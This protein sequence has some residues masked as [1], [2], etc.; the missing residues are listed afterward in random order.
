MRT[1]SDDGSVAAFE[2]DRVLAVRG[3]ETGAGIDDI[4]DRKMIRIGKSMVLL[5]ITDKISDINAAMRDVSD[6]NEIAN[7]KRKRDKLQK[8]L[9]LLAGIE[10]DDLK[11]VKPT[12]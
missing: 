1:A 4:G 8:I 2:K 6:R 3:G 9:S 10:E 7:L 5:Y 11:D 12:E